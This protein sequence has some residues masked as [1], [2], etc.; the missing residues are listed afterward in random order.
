MGVHDDPSVTQ[1]PPDIVYHSVQPEP[2]P[3]Q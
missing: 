1:L 3:P 2:L